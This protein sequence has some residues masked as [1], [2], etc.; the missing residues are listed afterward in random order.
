MLSDEQKKILEKGLFEE[1]KGV[2]ILY[3]KGSQ[4]EMGFQHGYLLADRIALM[5]N[6][7]L[8]GA[9]AVIAKTIKSDYKEAEKRMWIGQA[10]AEPFLPLELK[11]EMSGIADG[12]TAA[13]VDV[14]FKQILL[15]NTMYDQWCIY[16]HPHY[17]DCCKE[18]SKNKKHKQDGVPGS[19]FPGSAGCSSFSAWDDAAGGEGK[20][21]F[22]KNEDNLNL[23]GQLENRILVIA[24]PDDGYGH[25]FLT[26]PGMIGLDGGFNQDGI[27]MMTQYSASIHETMKGC[28]IGIFTRM[29]L[30][31]CSSLE[32]IFKLFRNNPR[33]TGIA[34][35]VADAKVKKAAVVEVSAARVCLRHPMPN[36][37]FL[38]QANNSCCYPGWQGYN[39]Y[40][41]AADQ[42]L[43]YRLGEIST[44]R[45]Y[46]TA[47]KDPYNFVVPAPSRME[48]YTQ[49]LHEYHGNITVEN[50]IKIMRDNYDPYTEKHRPRNG[51]SIS[52]NI[53]A[54]ISASYPDEVF[55]A[56]PPVGEFKARIANLWSLVAYPLDGDFWVAIKDFPA[57]QG[58]YEAFNLKKLL[59]K[60]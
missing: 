7:V 9:A 56:G 39:G 29:L 3:L 43:V 54:T 44:T 41:M 8:P 30:T 34:Y 49:L 20:L 32:D 13:D 46:L 26:F 52:N 42:A 28:G 17:W 55:L 48:R 18:I 51:T 53:L 5:V 37:G 40:N 23:P 36:T 19:I 27:T 6:R 15:W 31:H 60:G 21:I 2:K 4:Y 38:W 1:K 47:L 59:A 50:A 11:E 22:C 25:V 58:P 12:V 10:C 35:H 33:C 57:N 14:S 45:D 16:A 24:D